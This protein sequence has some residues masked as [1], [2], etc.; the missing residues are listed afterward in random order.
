LWL[1][2]WI[3]RYRDLYVASS[4]KVEAELRARVAD[5]EQRIIELTEELSQAKAKIERMEI[6][7]MPLSTAAG[8][9]YVGAPARRDPPKATVPDDELTWTGYLKKFIAEQ[10]SADKAAKEKA[11][12]VSNQGRQEEVH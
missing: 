7:L 2:Q 10:D 8:A 9:R 11:D 4:L 1:Q 3:N 12:G 6:V 5:K